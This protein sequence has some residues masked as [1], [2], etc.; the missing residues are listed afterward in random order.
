MVAVL[1]VPCRGR[2]TTTFT[3][4]TFMT[5]R[6]RAS[7]SRWQP[8][9]TWGKVTLSERP[10]PRKREEPLTRLQAAEERLNGHVHADRDVLQHLRV[11]PGQRGPF[12]LERWQ[13]RVLVV[14]PHGLLALL[15]GCLAFF[16][17]VIIEPAARVKLLLQKTTLLVLRVQPVLARLTHGFRIACVLTRREASPPLAHDQGLSVPFCNRR[18]L[19]GACPGM[20][21]VATPTRP[22]AADSRP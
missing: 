15:P 16:E 14:E 4:P 5:R 20:P 8:T 10:T 19:G 22:A 21:A 11:H 6:R 12:R 3:N 13:Q 17:Q 2:G 18:S 9:G 7:A 1:G